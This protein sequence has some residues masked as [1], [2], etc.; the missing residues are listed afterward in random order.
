MNGDLG[1]V[2]A[3]LHISSN[4]WRTLRAEGVE[5]RDEVRSLEAFSLRRPRGSVV[6]LS[7]TP[8][9]A[10]RDPRWQLWIR[11]PDKARVEF[12]GA[13]Q[14][15]IT[16]IVDGARTWITMPGGLSRIHERRPGSP[17]QLGPATQLIETTAISAALALDVVGR[18]E[19]LGREAFA[20]RAHPR[21]QEVRPGP[22]FHPLLNGGDEVQLAVDV[23]RGVVLRMEAFLGGSAF[24]RVE[25]TELAFDEEIPDE[26]FM[27][28]EADEAD[29]GPPSPSQPP[30][31]LRRRG[32][33]MLHDG[34][35]DNVIG[36]PAGIEAV[37]VRLTQWSLQLTASSR[38]RPGSS[39]M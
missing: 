20:V 31:N 25:F 22:G 6:S 5:W 21:E 35:P 36:Q 15:R 38:I 39:C 24:Y 34:P 27:F 7:G 9:P 18:T 28:P 8:G 16:Q 3:L 4:R 12:G 17:T 14:T 26:R 13:H 1:E 11:H 19:I 10:D 30:P 2:L 23:E 29:L 33:P 32:P 37:L